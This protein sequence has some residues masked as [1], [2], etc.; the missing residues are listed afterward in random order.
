MFLLNPFVCL[1]LAVPASPAC[2]AASAAPAEPVASVACEAGYLGVYVLSAEEGG[3]SVSRIMSGSPAEEIG[4][5]P[6]DRIVSLGGEEVDGADGLTAA[7]S[8]RHAGEEVEVA[9]HRGEQHI[10][11][12]VK[13]G[14]RSEAEA[15]GMFQVPPPVAEAAP[16]PPSGGFGFPQ[17][18]SQ[19][20]GQGHVELP[21]FPSAFT[22]PM[23]APDQQAH[24]LEQR[25]DELRRRMDERFADLSQRMQALR[26]ERQDGAFHE[27]MSR[28]QAELEAERGEQERRADELRAAVRAREAEQQQA[29]GQLFRAWSSPAPQG[30]GTS[31]SEVQALRDEVQ[32][33]RDEIREL[34][35]LMTR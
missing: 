32:S 10:T 4:L 35:E 24:Q 9:F 8:A 5:Q 6:G 22:A 1:A 29:A 2:A 18:Q 25:L 20:Q 11:R 12:T 13:L 33:L 21:R 23:F 17:W 14:K 28:L 31:A 3:A 15:G 7:I 30:A 26:E 34:K 16:A 27:R 19:G